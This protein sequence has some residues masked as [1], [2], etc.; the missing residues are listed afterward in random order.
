MSWLLLWT[1]SD[2]LYIWHGLYT[3]SLINLF[4]LQLAWLLDSFVSCAQTFNSEPIVPLVSARL[5]QVEKDLKTRYHDAKNKF[6]GRE[7]D[8]LIVILPDNNGSLYGW[9]ID[10]DRCNLFFLCTRI[11]ENIL[12]LYYFLCRWPQMYMWDNLGLVSQ[13]CWIKHVFK[14]S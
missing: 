14:M 11:C 5:D 4:C 6:Q 8:L 9:C 13:C 7:P 2:V 1:C 12:I 3:S 10:C